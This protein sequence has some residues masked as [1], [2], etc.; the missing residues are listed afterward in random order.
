M[1]SLRKS[2][3]PTSVWSALILVQRA[4]P[5]YPIEIDD[6]APFSAGDGEPTEVRKR[7]LFRRLVCWPF[8][9]AA[10]RRMMSQLGEMSDRELAD[11][12]LRREDLR[13]A[14]ALRLSDDP[15]TLFTARA[16]ERRDGWLEAS[17]MRIF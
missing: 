7:S 13:D 11:I 9:V 16:R 6:L 1:T 8:R 15:T 10:S 5:L 17:R 2:L 14:A 3:N 12:G 4:K